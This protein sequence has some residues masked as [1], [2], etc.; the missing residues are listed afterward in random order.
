M[1]AIQR[2]TFNKAHTFEKKAALEK[3]NKFVELLESST[4]TTKNKSESG[5]EI[6]IVIEGEDKAD[7]ELYFNPTINGYFAHVELWYYQFKLISM[8][9]KHNKET[10]NFKSIHQAFRYINEL[11]E[12]I[13]W[14]RKLLPNA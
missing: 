10:H 3:W 2:S 9:N 8:N 14:D 7:I 1:K 12:D 6:Y 5:K 4:L 13:K 11:L